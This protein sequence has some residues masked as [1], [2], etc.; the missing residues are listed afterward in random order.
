VAAA[1][2]APGCGDS[3]L[4][5][6]AGLGAAVLPAA[7]AFAP[8]IGASAADALRFNENARRI[9]LGEHP[10]Y[11]IAAQDFRGAPVG[12]DVR[13]VVATGILPAIDIMMVGR[14][15]GSGLVGM[16]IV[17][18]PM[19]CFEAAVKALDAAEVSTRRAT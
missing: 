8:V 17:S 5:E 10:H 6:C 13:K 4:I 1:D 9:A 14:R 19:A 16:G 2:V 12:V 3:F 18:P 7:P 11:R 15:P